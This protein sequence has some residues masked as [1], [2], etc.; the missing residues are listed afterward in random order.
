MVR[1]GRECKNTLAQEPLLR[2]EVM[3]RNS[4][5]SLRKENLPLYHFWTALIST[6]LKTTISCL[7][8]MMT[9]NPVE[10]T[11]G[12][13]AEKRT[14]HSQKN[15]EQILENSLVFQRKKV[16]RWMQQM[17]FK[18]KRVPLLSTKSTLNTPKPIIMQR[19]GPKA[20]VRKMY[21]SKKMK[22]SNLVWLSPTSRMTRR[23]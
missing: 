21:V 6:T 9:N 3:L 10:Q 19:N 23:T 12:I 8:Q 16:S 22:Y 11:M 2:P 15:K 5:T 14:K 13:K 18:S 1:N 20:Q 17:K 7:M 4:S